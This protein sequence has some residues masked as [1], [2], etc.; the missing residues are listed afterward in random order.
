MIYIYTPAIYEPLYSLGLYPVSRCKSQNTGS[1]LT[2]HSHDLGLALPPPLFRKSFKRASVSERGCLQR[3]AG[4]LHLPPRGPPPPYLKLL[5]EIGAGPGHDQSHHI[6]VKC[7]QDQRLG[8]PNKIIVGIVL[9]AISALGQNTMNNLKYQIHKLFTIFAAPSTSS[10]IHIFA[11]LAPFALATAA[12]RTTS[13]QKC[14]ESVQNNRNHCQRDSNQIPKCS[15]LEYQINE[16]STSR[17]RRGPQG[18]SIVPPVAILMPKVS[19][20]R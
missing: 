10:K 6:G 12:L 20:S 3:R 5:H 4:S 1:Q 14:K 15:H 13:R 8:P 19:Q 7:L 9:Q 17:S 16:I 18:P 2:G 11:F